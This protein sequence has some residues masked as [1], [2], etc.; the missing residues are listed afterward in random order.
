MRHAPLP[1]R[2]LGRITFWALAGVA[3]LVS[4]DVVFLV[5]LGPGEEFVRTLRQAAHDYWAAASVAL[6]VTGVAAAIAFSLRIRWLKRRAAA[7][8]ASAVPLGPR[9]YLRRVASTWLALFPIVAL[10]FVVQESLEHLRGH[11]HLLGVEALLGAKYPLA[12]PIVGLITLGAALLGGAFGGA[13]GAL[14]TAIADRL[15]RVVVLRPPVR[16][17]RAPLRLASSRRSPLAGTPAERAPPPELVQV[18]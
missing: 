9:R 18:T 16:L 13:E 1:R 8:G 3:L 12:V 15:R 10:G 6:T 11:D 5:Q 7:V 2:T 4:H 17:A 14:L